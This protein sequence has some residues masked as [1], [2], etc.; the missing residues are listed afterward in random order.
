MTRSIPLLVVS[1]WIAAN[2]PAAEPWA[3]PRLPVTRGLVGWYDA[4]RLDD[5]LKSA[6][7]PGPNGETPLERWPDAS[8][9]GRDLLA[10]TADS[11]PDYLVENTFR[12]VRFDGKKTF[13]RRSAGRIEAPAITGFAVIA[14][15]ANRRAFTGFLASF[16]KERND[17]QTGF[18]VDF[19]PFHTNAVEA[20]NIEGAGTNGAANLLKKPSPFGRLLRIGFVAAPGPGGISVRVNGEGGNARDR[21]AGSVLRLDELVVGARQYGNGI[22]AE[23]CGFYEGDIAEVLLYDRALDEPERNDVER[24]L[25][26]KYAGTAAVL[27]PESALSGGSGLVRV[28]SPPPVQMFVPGFEV[29][30]LPLDLT[31]VNNLLYRPDGRLVAL[32]YS[33]DILLLTDSDGDGLEDR[34]A[35]FFEGRGKLLGP[36]GMDLLPSKPGEGMRVVVAAKGKCLLVEDTDNDDVADREREIANGWRELPHGVDAL[37]VAVDRRD[38]SV[39]FGLGCQNYTDAYGTAKDAIPYSIESERGTIL[40]IAP[41]FSSREIVAT[42]IRFPVALRFHPSGDLFCTDQEGATWLPNGNP[43]DELLH[44]ERGRHYG[45]PPRHP[46][47]LPN[48]IDEPSVFDYAPQ[49]Q[50]TCGLNFNSPAEGNRAFGPAWWRDDALV[51]G[52]SRGKLYRT[53]LVTTDAGYVAQSQLLASLPMLPADAC[54]SPAGDLVIAAHGGGPD[55]GSGAAGKGKL[56]KIH[57]LAD[58]PRPVLAWPQGPREVRVTFDAP[59]SAEQLRNVEGGA[60]IDSGA[61]VAAGD[62]FE[63]LW[64][65]YNVVQD[66]KMAPRKKL[67]V[68]SLQVSPDRRTLILATDAHAQSTG[69]ALTL[70]GLGRAA[71]APA[72]PQG[73]AQVP[74]TDLAYNLDGVQAEW[75]GRD[76]ASA[77]SESLWLP[78]LDPRVSFELTQGSD[79]HASFRKT[80]AAPG[81]L[82]LRTTLDLRR[83]LRPEVQPG[84]PVGYELPPERVR[85]LFRSREPFE[86]LADKTS[87]AVQPRDGQP[88]FEAVIE[89][90][91]PR[92][93]VE[94]ALP[95]GS[96]G[97]DLTV[98]WS[99]NEDPRPRAFPLRRLRLPWAPTAEAAIPALLATDHP[100]LQGGS[101]R[102]G[103]SVFFGEEAGCFKCHRVHGQ[104]AAIGPDLSNLPHRDYDSVLRDI[105]TPSFAINPDY[106]TH[107]IVHADGRVL[108]GAVR[109]EGDHL[110][111]SD[112]EGKTAKIARAD[113]EQMQASSVSIMPSGLPQKVGPDR[114]RD[115]LTFLLT[116]PPRMPEYGA[117]EPPA[118]RE[119]GE[120]AAVLEGSRLPETLARKKIILVSGAKDHGPG[121]HDYPAWKGA[122]LRLFQMADGIDVTAVDEWPTDDDFRTA[123]T[124][125]FY[126]HGRWT[127]ER[128]RAIDAYLAR[129]GGLVYLHYA[130]D[131]GNEAPAFAQRIGLAFTAGSRFRHGPI[132][133][134]LLNACPDEITRNFRR[135]HFHDESYWG[136]AGD[137]S[138]LSLVGTGREENREQ[139]LLWTLEPA[140]GRVFVSI[141]GHYSWTFDDPLFRVLILRGIAWSAREPVDRFN[142]LVTPGARIE[143]RPSSVS[144]TSVPGPSAPAAPVR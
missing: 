144:D 68:R 32:A 111:V 40:R 1:L 113:V 36:I 130:V 139:P 22:A 31:N 79:P 136:M 6:G 49:H 92:A 135:V 16:E 10:P 74:E 131:G 125:V 93:A 57:A 7:R 118:P 24:Y 78:H 44:I 132:D 45:F 77:A 106:L 83:M 87:V 53:K 91:D 5:A 109:S 141:L 103:K 80:I 128:A 9:H 95:T 48:V 4:S 121:E 17:Y 89:T 11:R 64:P 58:V 96:E 76:A 54:L 102:R 43:F 142:D 3:D 59:L 25:E 47:H 134:E 30:E 35:T 117:L 70:R 101:W 71:D 85:V 143:Y 137:P 122:W 72:G 38:G 23:V 98:F 39:Y 138:R 61:A 55:W 82:R 29:R 41:D 81:T 86:L 52:Y 73:R 51:T 66:Q 19:G 94:I 33:G 2:A 127:A 99:T 110:L 84:S 124:I 123:D 120:V 28:K 69:Y 67:T 62:R 75:R 46:K 20:I 126:Q 60:A 129:G 65:G 107:M 18:N 56:Y 27:L 100:A 12:A 97:A 34:T 50:S 116:P 14:L 90:G 37:G 8:G 114:M 112:A 15:H 140:R 108:T 21:A 42:G 119:W 88:G 115:L 13:L 63:A 104:G 105:A 133:L 26:A